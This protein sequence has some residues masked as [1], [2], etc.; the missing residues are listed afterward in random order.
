M[1]KIIRT[2]GTF[3]VLFFSTLVCGQE[4]PEKY[5]NAINALETGLKEGKYDVFKDALA[6]DF[7]AGI[8]N[9]PTVQNVIPQILQQYPKLVALKILQFDENIAHIEYVFNGIGKQESTITFNEEGEI[10]GIE[11]FD[12]ILKT[13][14]ATSRIAGGGDFSRIKTFTTK[15]ELVEGLIFIKVKLNGKE[16]DFILDSGAPAIVLNTPYFESED[17]G[18]SAEGVSGKTAIRNIKIDSFNWNGIKTGKTELIGL[19]LSHLEEET[20]R[21]FKGL[22]GHSILKD[23]ELYFDYDKKELTLFSERNTQFHN[24][25]KPIAAMNFDYQ[26]HIPVLDVIIKEEHFK[27]GIDTGAA[28]NLIGLKALKRLPEKSYRIKGETDLRGA[29]KNITKVSQLLIK[30]VILSGREYKKMD[31]VSSDISNLTDGY[32]ISLDGLIGF[33]YL[34]RFKTSIDFKN[35]KVYLWE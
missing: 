13:S 19:E 30:N 1:N 31:F 16:E 14:A 20:G 28:T 2:I 12:N 10:T 22:I 6:E 5:K 15:F 35:K 33:P 27:L 34:S 23:Y 3:Y 9:Q 4:I 8:Y 11:F 32:N 26:A 29:D 21:K 24:T 25:I 18:K 7:K 17:S